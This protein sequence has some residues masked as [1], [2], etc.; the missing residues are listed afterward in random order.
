M[1]RNVILSI[2]IGAL[3]T[4]LPFWQWDGTV[5][6]ALGAVVIGVI[7]LAVLTALEKAPRVGAHRGA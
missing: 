1:M 4:Y 5:E 6:Q 2:I 7:T 3:S